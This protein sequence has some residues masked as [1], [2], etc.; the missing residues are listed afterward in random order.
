M[1]LG[2]SGKKGSGKS[3]AANIIHGLVLKKLNLIQDWT[4]GNSG[5]LLIKTTRS[6]GEVGWGELWM[7]RQDS[8]FVEYAENN[9]WPYVKLYSFADSL[10]AICHDLFDIPFRCLHGTDEEKNQLQQHLLWENMP[11]VT[12][13]FAPDGM[14]FH[15]AGPMTAR[16]F[17]QFFGTEIGRRMYAPIWTEST[18]KRILRDGSELSIVAD[19]RFENEV[20]AIEDAGGIVL[21]LTRDEHSDSH[22]S[23]TCLDNYAFKEFIHNN[24]KSLQEFV[25]EVVKFYGRIS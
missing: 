4:I 25:D 12:S 3:T 21:R 18:I 20:R 16:E 9:I 13:D 2:I 15:E 19:V 8:Q 10:K 22:E 1:I 7:S 6:D 5:Q 17:M 11:G 23:E 14:V 24:G